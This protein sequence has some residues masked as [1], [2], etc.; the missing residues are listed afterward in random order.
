MNTSYNIVM[1]EGGYILY[2]NRP[3]EGE[4]ATLSSSEVRVF[5]DSSALLNYLHNELVGSN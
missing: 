5:T 2:I 1:A 3:S 4:P